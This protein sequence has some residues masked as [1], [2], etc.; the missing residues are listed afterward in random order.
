LS[1][2][3]K[4]CIFCRIIRG[5]SLAEFVYRGDSVVIFK[6]VRPDAPVHLLVVPRKHIRS[7][8]D[9]TDADGPL[10]S[11]MILRAK[12]VAK[13]LCIHESGYRLLFNVEWGGGQVVFHLHMHMIGGWR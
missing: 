2:G 8:N 6:D 13:Q 7:V 1:Q 10:V 3:E 4:D 5:E 11:E 9:L 12:E